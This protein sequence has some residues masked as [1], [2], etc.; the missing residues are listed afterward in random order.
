MSKKSRKQAASAD[1]RAGRDSAQSAPF[2]H[3]LRVEKGF[4]LARLDPRATPG[5]TGGKSAGAKALP[6]FT[7]E[8]SDLQERL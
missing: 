8:I 5:F 4:S 2:S 1:A 3:A 6:E 7:A